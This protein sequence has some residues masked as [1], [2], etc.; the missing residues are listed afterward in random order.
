MSRVATPICGGVLWMAYF[1]ECFRDH[2]DA[3]IVDSEMFDGKSISTSYTVV[4]RSHYLCFI[5]KPS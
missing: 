5:K 4:F 1:P 3:E 2:F